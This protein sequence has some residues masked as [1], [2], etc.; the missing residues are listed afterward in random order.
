[1]GCFAPVTEEETGRGAAVLLAALLRQTDRFHQWLCQA[2][3]NLNNADSAALLSCCTTAGRFIPAFHHRPGRPAAHKAFQQLHELHILSVSAAIV[4][5]SVSLDSPS[6][7]LKGPCQKRS[8]PGAILKPCFSGVDSSSNQLNNRTL[9][10]AHP[11]K[12][13]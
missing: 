10:A 7:T 13:R 3:Q 12:Q 8:K 9:A 11:G 2:H 5:R 1:M 4:M 6:P